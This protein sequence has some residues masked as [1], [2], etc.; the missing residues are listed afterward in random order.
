[1]YRALTA[2]AVSLFAPIAWAAIPVNINTADAQT[3][4][5]SLD[6]IGLSKAQAIV[7]QRSQNG[8]FKSLEEL[9]LVKG[10]GAS[11]IERNREAIRLTSDTPTA[12]KKASKTKD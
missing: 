4:A 10:V 7:E 9:T 2:I 6:G 11:L 5:D 8:P 1:M 12:P 3:I